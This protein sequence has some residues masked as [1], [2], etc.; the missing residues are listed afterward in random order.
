MVKAKAA[1]LN[2]NE[3]NEDPASFGVTPH[4][5]SFFRETSSGQ[6]A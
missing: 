3:N 4:F 5:L 2:P 1:L 6:R